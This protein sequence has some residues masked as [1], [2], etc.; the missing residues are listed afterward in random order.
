MLLDLE[1]AVTG[2]ASQP[3]WLPWHDQAGARVSHVPDFFARRAAAPPAAADA[4]IRP[5]VPRRNSTQMLTS[6]LGWSRAV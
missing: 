6:L 4:P 5:T 2:I 3:F 1:P